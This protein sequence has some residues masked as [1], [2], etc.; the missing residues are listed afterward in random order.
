MNL[1]LSQITGIGPATKTAL[2]NVGIHDIK[3]LSEAHAEEIS[4]VPKA[5]TLISRAKAHM[6]TYVA[7]ETK[8]MVTMESKSVIENQKPVEKPEISVSEEE[9]EFVYL[10]ENHTWW[11]LQINLPR[12]CRAKDLDDDEMRQDYFLRPAIIYDLSVDPNNRIS[13][14]CCWIVEDNLKKTESLCTMTYSPQL[15]LHFNLD[16]PDLKI[17]LRPED[18][19]N[20]PSQ[21][22]LSNTLWEIN[23]MKR[24]SGN[25]NQN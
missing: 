2:V 5:L 1:D 9:N 3:Q 7:R 17:S 14:V 22:A 24:L 21:N 6:N 10:I 23:L 18:L 19:K 8:P 16:L 4:I 15:L 12:S 20:L 13:F 25:W 11:E